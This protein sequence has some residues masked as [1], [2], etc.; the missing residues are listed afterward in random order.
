MAKIKH[1]KSESETLPLKRVGVIGG[2]GQ[3]AT[4]DILNR[5]L[6]YSADH[7]PQY[8][9]RGYPPMD[10]IMVNE[11]PMP[12]NPD[13]TYPEPVM[14]TLQFLESAKLAGEKA[15]FLIMTANTPHMFRHEIEKAAGKPLLSIVDVAVEE[16]KRRNCKKVGLTAI[17]LTLRKELFQK[18]LKEAGIESVSL[19]DDLIQRLES[20][21][22]YQVQE[23]EDPKEFSKI[24]YEVVEYLRNQ[25]VDGII[26]GCTEIPI[27]LGDKANEPDIINPSQLL[28]EAVVKK[29]LEEDE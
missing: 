3:W 23:G 14:P 2:M 5:T 6:R 13:G 17:G 26:L 10:I 20:E 16:A 11:A 15:D 19:P 25:N 24:A 8:G 1:A 7:L 27:L 18:P 4:I 9:N 29:A 22:I 12:L 28:A 21:G